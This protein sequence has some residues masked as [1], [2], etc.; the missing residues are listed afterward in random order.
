MAMKKK[1][2]LVDDERAFTEM[3]RLNLEATGLYEVVV[4]NNAL[5]ALPTAVKHRPDIIVMDVV[6]TNQKGTDLAAQFKKSLEFKQIPIV[7]LTATI[8]G[9][10][11]PLE[12][13]QFMGC[14]VLPKPTDLKALLSVLEQNLSTTC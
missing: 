10:E 14:P 4:E 12:E 11:S 8:S 2:L 5:Y 7:F 9:H 1:I 3:L 13:D 6:M